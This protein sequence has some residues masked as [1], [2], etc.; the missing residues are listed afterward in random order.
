MSSL[1]E[2]ALQKIGR[3]VV[4]LSKIEGML[5][6]ILINSNYQYPINKISETL[7]ARK[8]SFKTKTLGQLIKEYFK[9]FDND[10]EHMHQ[11]PEDRDEAWGSMSLSIENEE[12]TLPDQKRSIEFLV[13]ERNRLVHYMLVKFNPESKQDCIELIN[14]LDEQNEMIQ[15]EYKNIQT[16]MGTLKEGLIK[17]DKSHINQKHRVK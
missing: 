14:E 4:N 13:S 17:L 11:Y 9:I 16:L 10:M 3:N 15:R 1:K 8:K 5:K 6:L 2:K 7:E 12:G